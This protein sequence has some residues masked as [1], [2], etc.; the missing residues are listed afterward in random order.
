ML[1]EQ[2]CFPTF[3]LDFSQR[4]GGGRDGRG[5]EVGRQR[6]CGVGGHAAEVFLPEHLP[7]GWGPGKCFC[8]IL[9]R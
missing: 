9:Q 4:H 5:T 8:A 1:S 2:L 7:P 3:T 6:F